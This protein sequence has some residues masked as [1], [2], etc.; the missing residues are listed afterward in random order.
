MTPCLQSSTLEFHTPIHTPESQR[1]KL[2]RSGELLWL[3]L[4]VQRYTLILA[5]VPLHLPEKNNRTGLPGVACTCAHAPFSPR[6]DFFAGTTTSK[7]FTIVSSGTERSL[8]GERRRV[9]P[10]KEGLGCLP[11]QDRS[12]VLNLT[13]PFATLTLDGDCPVSSDSFQPLLFR[14]D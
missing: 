10:E 12:A 13:M 14:S 6:M 4:G 7:Q 11:A 3:L 2:Q 9:Q 8:T 5:V 1:C